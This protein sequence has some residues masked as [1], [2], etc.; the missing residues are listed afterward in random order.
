M[1][2]STQARGRKRGS[3]L[4]E[5]EH[6]GLEVKR[7]R[8]IREEDERDLGTFFSGKSLRDSK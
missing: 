3:S 2:R 1:V 5:S 4:H 7:V 6:D 8:S